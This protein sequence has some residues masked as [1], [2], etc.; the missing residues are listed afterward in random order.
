MYG[1]AERA[2]A[3]R[4]RRPP[5]RGDGADEDLDIVPEEARRQLAD[6]LEWFGRVDLEQI[7]NLVAWER[8]LPWLEVECGGGR[9]GKL[10]VTHYSPASFDE[11]GRALQTRRFDTVQVPLNPRER[12]CERDAAPARGR[13]RGRGDRHAPVRRGRAAAPCALAGGAEPLA[14]FGVTTW[15]QALLKWALSDERV[16]LVIPATRRPERVAENAAAGEPPWFGREERAYVESLVAMRVWEGRRFAVVVEDGYEIADT[17]D[18]VAIV[19]LDAEER[20]V[21][22]RQRRVA[23]AARCSSSRQGSIDEGEE[24]LASAQRELREETGLHGG[25][26]RELASFW[27]SPGFVNERVTVFVAE[28]VAEGE[29][30][31]DEGEELEVVRWTLS[32]VEARLHELEDATTLIGLLLYLRER[33]LGVSFRRQCASASPRR[34]SLRS[35]ASR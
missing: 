26:W 32:E 24:P 27:T 7:H 25:S 2:L 9:I 11:L 3:R 34:S 29:P 10:G 15:P 8:H 14:E 19:A 33:A 18:A 21:F 23:S 4:A 35:T 20:V 22:V 1:G 17:P 5:R 13:P 30:E 16:D 12:T 6:Q 31:P 28:G